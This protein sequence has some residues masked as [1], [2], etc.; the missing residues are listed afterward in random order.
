[1]H[2]NA[3]SLDKPLAPV[4]QEV[5]THALALDIPNRLYAASSSE[6]AKISSTNDD[7]MEVSQATKRKCQLANIYFLDHYFDLLTYIH[8]RKVRTEKVKEELRTKAVS[9]P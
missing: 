1:M 3:L 7:A 4:D 6:S 9:I 8:Q 2:V 5:I